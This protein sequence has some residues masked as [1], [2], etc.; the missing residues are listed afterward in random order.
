MITEGKRFQF[1]ARLAWRGSLLLFFRGEGGGMELAV[2]LVQDGI[3]AL[4]KAHMS[5]TPSLV[6]FLNPAFKTCPVLV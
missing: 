1:R 2:R 4:G 3:C 5:P 6:S